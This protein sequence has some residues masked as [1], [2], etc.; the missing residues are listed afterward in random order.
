M[1]RLTIN[2]HELFRFVS[3]DVHANMYILLSDV[4]ALVVDPH[5]AP[6]ALALLQ[7]AGIAECSMLLTHEHPDH[8][9]G[10]YRFQ[11]LF[12]LHHF[13][14]KSYHAFTKVGILKLQF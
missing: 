1:D 4:R 11:Q 5:P 12:H 7:E 9:G 6:Q 13:A 3:E 8:T 10:V 14:L 2:A